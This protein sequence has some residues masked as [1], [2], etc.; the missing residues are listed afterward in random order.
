MERRAES[1][2]GGSQ[3]GRDVIPSIADFAAEIK[4]RGRHATPTGWFQP[5]SKN[6]PLGFMPVNGLDAGFVGGFLP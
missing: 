5:I 3:G 1:V 6:R 4:M 2:K